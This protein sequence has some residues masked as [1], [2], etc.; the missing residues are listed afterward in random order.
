MSQQSHNWAYTLRKTTIQ[1]DT[2]ISM[3]IE[4]LFTIDRTWKPPRCPIIDEWI[5]KIWYI[6]SREYYSPIKSNAFESCL[7][8]WT[9]VVFYTE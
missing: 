6:S 4:A 9:K 5:K 7:M 2:Y 3:F 8:K 1:K